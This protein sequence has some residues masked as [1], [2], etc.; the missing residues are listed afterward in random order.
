MQGVTEAHSSET[1]NGNGND[2]HDTGPLLNRGTLSD[3]GIVSAAAEMEQMVDD[4]VGPESRKSKTTETTSENRSSLHRSALKKDVPWQ[5]VTAQ[6]FVWQIHQSSPANA[7]QPPGHASPRPSLLPSVFQTPFTPR[8]S[9]RPG[10]S[11]RPISASQLPLPSTSPAV[12]SSTL[13]ETDLIQQQQAIEPKTSPAPTMQSTAQL[14]YYQTPTGFNTFVRNNVQ[15]QND[16]SPWQSSVPS[17]TTSDTTKST[18]RVSSGSP[19]G[20]IGAGRPGGNTK[21]PTSGELN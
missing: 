1:I 8:P 6:D 20:A 18:K 12:R 19:F 15:T 9:E 13:F 10:S 21:T 4:I 5:P 3:I 17:A 11:P 7:F 16:S 14:N 2:S